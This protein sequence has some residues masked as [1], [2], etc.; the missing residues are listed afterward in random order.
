MSPMQ[1][2]QDRRAVPPAGRALVTG[3]AGFIGSHLC[4]RLLALGWTVIG[5][6][7]FTPYYDRRHKERNLDGPRAQP[8]FA[9]VELDVAADELA[10]VLEGVDTVFH[11]A[12]Q[13][14]VRASFGSGFGAYVRHNVEGTQRVFEAA[15][16]AG[17]RRVVYASSSSV[18]GD[19]ARYPVREDDPLAPRSPYGVTKRTCEDLAR[20]YR[21]LGLDSVGLRYFTVYGPRQRPDMAMRRLCETAVRR[22]PFVLHGDG[23]QS[24]D[25][26]YVA[27]AVDATVLAALAPDPGAVL[28]IG[29]GNEATM[30]DVIGTIERLAGHRLDIAAGA[31]QRGDVRR[32][33]ADPGLAMTRLGWQPRTDLETGLRHQLHWVMDRVWGTDALGLATAGAQR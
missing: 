29:G 30:L 18:Y 22:A 20:V 13:P 4:E 21:D 11:L 17:V 31:P 10:P 26:T 14:G 12:A 27:D 7:A 2:P 25:F 16:A 28:N 32:T 19:A 23:R 9:D 33:G 24:R 6:D 5:V 1:L 15:L 8:R 3:C